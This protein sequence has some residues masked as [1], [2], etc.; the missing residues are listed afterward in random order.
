MSPQG[1]A[2]DSR[3]HQTLAK[4]DAP[5]RVRDICRLIDGARL[6]LLDLDGC[7]AFGD[8]PH[9]AAAAL[10]AR[11]GGRYAIVSNN[12]TETPRSMAM[13]LR[14]RGLAVDP[15]RIFLAGALMVDMLA[16]QPARAPIAL[17]AGPRLAA[18]ARRRGLVLAQR[19]AD[20]V[21]TVALARDTTLTYRGLNL[22]VAALA[23]GA[24][25][26]VSNPDLTHPGPG[27]LP[28]VET[29]AIL[30]ALRAC[31]P[32]LATQ[33]VGKPEPMM[34]QS[35]LDRFGVAAAEV[36]MVGDN[37]DTDGIGAAR[38]GI[39]AV[40]VGPSGTLASIADLL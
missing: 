35:A 6:V 20:D 36:V 11:L 9:P 2:E 1:R 3:L 29:G 4:T 28:V 5:R 8:V 38:A 12:S 39:P 17:Y 18:H 27:G 30:A 19:G 14:R 10:L 15:G 33:V 16:S 31:R 40:L 37:P 23:R 34:F 21:A 26:V 7:L 22:I 24:E 13:I 25:L 32:G